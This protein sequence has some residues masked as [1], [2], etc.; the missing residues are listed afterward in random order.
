MKNLKVVLASLL[1]IA[2]VVAFSSFSSK[3]YNKK[4]FD[5]IC[6]YYIGAQPATT[7][8]IED[9]TKWSDA[10]STS[11]D[12]VVFSKLC[13][14]CFDDSQLNGDSQPNSTVLQLVND[15]FQAL[16]NQGQEIITGTAPNQ[17]HTGIFV[18]RKA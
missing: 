17:V 4:A 15:N 3:N 16:T 7:T 12:C 18:Y 10:Q 13:A 2:G 9:P 14:I 5:L 1:L 11:P 8:D 6:F